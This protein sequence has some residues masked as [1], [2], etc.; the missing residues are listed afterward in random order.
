M[1]STT[2]TLKRLQRGVGMM[3]L[4]ATFFSLVLPRLTRADESTPAGWLRVGRK[5]SRSVT[6][7]SQSGPGQSLLFSNP[8][9]PAAGVRQTTHSRSNGHT[10][11]ELQKLKDE[12]PSVAQ[13][14]SVKILVREDGWYRVGRSQ[15]I[16]AGL[17][18]KSNSKFLQLFADGVEIPILVTEDKRG[19]LDSIEFYGEGL[20]T[21][22]TDTRVYWLVAGNRPG[23]RVDSVQARPR[24]DV[25]Q[26]FLC[27]MERCDRKTYFASLLNGDAP[28][29]FGDML[30]ASPVDQIISLSNVDQSAQ[31]TATLEVALQGVNYVDHQV[32]VSINEYQL[33]TIEFWGQDPVVQSF[34]VPQWVLKNGDNA[35]NLTATGG[36]SDVNLVDRTRISYWHQANIEGDVALYTV[37][38]PDDSGRVFQ[39]QRITG[40]TNPSAKTIDITDPEE[41][42][43][44][45]GSTEKS[46]A[47]YYTVSYNSSVL[48]SGPRTII[49]LADTMAKTPVAVI[50]NV[51]SFL[52][53]SSNTADLIIISTRELKSAVS[54]LAAVRQKQ[55]YRVMVVD[56]EDIYDEFSFGAK[57]EQAIRDFLQFA[58][59]QWARAPR[60]VLLAGD[61][62]FDPRNYLGFGYGD[63]VPT[64]LIDTVYTET[65]SDDWFVDFDDDG[66]PE[67]AIGRLPVR[68]S[69]ELEQMVGKIVGYDSRNRAYDKK[70]MFVSDRNDGWDFEGATRSA[71]SALPSTFEKQLIL[72]SENTDPVTKQ[73]ILD[74]INS[75]NTIVNYAGHGSSNLWRGNLLTSQDAP[76][77]TNEGRLSVFIVM[78]CLNG[79]FQ[80][81]SYDCLAESLMKSRAGAVAVWASSAL[82][83]PFEQSTMNT[84]MLRQLSLNGSLTRQPVTIGQAAIA[85]K[86]AV[87]DM[88]LRRTWV[89]FGDPTTV[90]R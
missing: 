3:L 74:G 20:D 82:T 19:A 40:L 73:R 2:S 47:G 43:I 66:I 60:F 63:I 52:E 48:G 67:M 76:S 45:L 6:I 87:G 44:L 61:A 32:Q 80:D 72:R 14:S 34:P 15:L 5:L 89:L 55:G 13:M 62:T 28:N 17:N 22:A 70:A 77:L 69:D 49:T 53:K 51:P 26:S 1:K 38:E 4:T 29:F 24:G 9:A 33:G 21:L 30:A 42:R 75:G 36:R 37:G 65:A 57:S 58:S 59:T 35:V 64:K 39:S 8:S 88:D 25:N 81:V 84:E 12:P 85:A 83:F 31:G 41:P 86:A 18:P 46:T 27:T 7:D 68:T 56:V 11:V 16:S 23:Q 78:D 10:S 90:V 71:A 54:T 50:A 79:L